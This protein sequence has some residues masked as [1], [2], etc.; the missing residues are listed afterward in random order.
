M[1]GWVSEVNANV[2]CGYKPVEKAPRAVADPT[3]VVSIEFMYA[4]N[5]ISVGS[6]VGP[7]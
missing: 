6:V 5:L 7:P 1:N 2:P 3:G 4:V